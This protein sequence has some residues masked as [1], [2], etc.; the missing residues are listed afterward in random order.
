MNDYEFI[1]KFTSLTLKDICKD[2]RVDVPNLLNKRCS[3][4]KYK[5]VRKEIESRM[6]KLLNN[7]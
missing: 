5:L 4:E 3:K 2:L 1:R 6:E 7:E